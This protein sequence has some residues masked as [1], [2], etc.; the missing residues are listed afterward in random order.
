MFFG[1]KGEGVHIDTNSGG[2]IT[3]NGHAFVMLV[4][5]DQLEIL[6]HTGGETLVTVELE[7]G[8]F[9]GFGGVLGL[10]SQATKKDLGSLVTLEVG[11]RDG[12]RLW[13]LNPGITMSVIH[14]V[15]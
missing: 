1:L 13:E 10:L 5:L 7:F 8:G 11:G 3:V 15:S 9:E 2:G 12:I 4:G 6:G 14:P